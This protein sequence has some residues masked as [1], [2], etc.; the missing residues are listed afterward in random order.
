MIHQLTS[1][2]PTMEPVTF[3]PGMNVV[4]AER[5]EDST[6]KDSRNGVGKSTLIEIIH[7]CLG[8]DVNRGKEKAL[9][10]KHLADFTFTLEMEL[11]DFRFN[12]SRMGSAGNR[13]LISGDL[14]ELPKEWHPTEE[15]I[16][17]ELVYS[18][19][20]WK[21][22]LGW[23]MFELP[24]PERKGKKIETQIYSPTFR[25]LFSYF[26]RKGRSSFEKPFE[27]FR[28]QQE[29]NIQVNN[30]FLLGLGWDFAAKF[31]LNKDQEKDV[32]LLE[33]SAS[34]GVLKSLAGDLGTLEAT[35]VT[36][37]DRVR[38]EE[39]QL[40]TFHVHPQ[41][42]E[43]NETANE[44][45]RRIH[46]LT[47]D[48]VSSQK[49][50]S[51]YENSL[52]A[53]VPANN[54]K[55]LSLYREAGVVMPDLVSKTLSDVANFHNKIIE[56]RR[57][58]LE[59]EITQL[60]Q[61]IIDNDTKIKHLSDERATLM[62][63]L[64]THGALDEYTGLQKRHARAVAELEEINQKIQRI[65][66]VKEKKSSLRIEREQLQQQMQLD[67]DERREHLARAISL[68]NANTEALYEAPGR[69][70][71]N[72]KSTGYDFD[73]DIDR[74]GSGGVEQMEVFCYD[75]MLAQ[76]WAEKEISSVFLVH[77]SLIWD[78]VDERQVAHAI[79]LAHQ[80]AKESN[81]QYICCINS[82]SIPTQDFS[83][84]FVF[85]DYI[86]KTLHDRDESGTLLGFRF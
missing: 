12:V 32:K 85:S 54:E 4:V 34:S 25:S 78:G 36:L 15:K 17:G 21:A 52:T 38:S 26:V 31:Q 41:Y 8:M 48:N 35:R 13:I 33:K 80:R 51:Y 43:I 45:T 56:N 16:T 79:E 3:V 58:F 44:Y 42:K 29:W 70:I 46:T 19:N 7:F 50:V 68:F 23:L 40:S 27:H 47:N 61:H 67:Y 18:L 37:Q 66:E 2:I 5:T 75:L 49:M 6:E 14:S 22:V 53:E 72:V 69:L 65:R 60:R 1:N 71:I 55:L 30:A 39:N 73:V 10:G 57:S 83:K 74:K 84:E 86:C 77:D 81:F 76:I 28:R 11:R 82:D 24:L 64:R 62:G 9:F 20:E 59:S 63:I